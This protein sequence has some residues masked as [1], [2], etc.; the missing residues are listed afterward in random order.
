MEY[1][2]SFFE[3]LDELVYISDLDTHKLIYM[4]RRLRQ[5]LGYGDSNAYEGNKCYEVL[6]GRHSPCSFCTNSALQEGKFLSWTHKNPV[7]NKRYLIKDTVQMI[8]GRRCRIEIAI[9]ID[10]EVVCN[11]PYYY[12]RSETILNDCLQRIFS[13]TNPGKGV[14]LVLEYL[15][16]TF[17]CDRAYVFEISQEKIYN[18]YEW[19]GEGVMP[20]KDAL[21]DIPI[22][23]LEW[24]L[25]VF[26]KN[27]VLVLEDLEDIREQH[28]NS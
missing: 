14:E 9:D 1:C 28:P 5:S 19:C 20:Q 22:S 13:T 17:E 12:A 26:Q 8:E 18:S 27:R 4:N 10:S 23:F 2:S 16:Q 6:Q 24:W 21:Q 11:T 15:G 3:E 25:K 7:L